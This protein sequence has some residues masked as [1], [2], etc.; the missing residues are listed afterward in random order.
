VN[1]AFAKLNQQQYVIM[2][3]PSEFGISGKLTNW[4][5]SKDISSIKVKTLVIGAKF[6]TMDPAYMEWMSKQI[7]GAAFH[8]CANGSHMC[9]WD[10]QKSY[11]KGLIDFLKS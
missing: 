10:D 9:M 11:F 7:N 5:R 2:Q 3:G 8:L 4:D 1:R 6:D